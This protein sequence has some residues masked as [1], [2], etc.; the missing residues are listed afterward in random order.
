MILKEIS[1]KVISGIKDRVESKAARRTLRDSLWQRL[2]KSIN[3]EQVGD[4]V[5]IISDYLNKCFLTGKEVSITNFGT[6][7]IVKYNLVA[8]NLRPTGKSYKALRFHIAP[9]F[10]LKLKNRV[11]KVRP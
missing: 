8:N 2:G 10:N 4:C 3:Q 6:F 1:L 5:K 7:S 11:K 9:T